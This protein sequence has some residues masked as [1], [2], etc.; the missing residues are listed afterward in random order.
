MYVITP[1]T[2]YYQQKSV[3]QHDPWTLYP[4]HSKLIFKTD[5]MFDILKSYTSIYGFKMTDLLNPANKVD[6]FI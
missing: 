3:K 5:F 6:G 2:Q 4:T 1:L